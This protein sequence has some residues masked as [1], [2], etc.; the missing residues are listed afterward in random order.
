MPLRSNQ[1][2][3]HHPSS[4]YVTEA[5]ARGAEHHFISSNT[6]GSVLSRDQILNMRYTP[7]R[8]TAEE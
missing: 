7:D 8:I 4:S 3:N 1:E 2:P 5:L 6:R